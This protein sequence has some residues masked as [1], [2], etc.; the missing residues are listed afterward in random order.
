MH[1]TTTKDQLLLYTIQCFTHRSHNSIPINLPRSQICGM[2]LFGNRFVENAPITRCPR[3]VLAQGESNLGHHVTFSWAVHV[4]Y[5]C[6]SS[7]S[8]HLTAG[9]T[10]NLRQLGNGPRFAVVALPVMRKEFNSV[11]SKLHIFLESLI[12]SAG[13]RERFIFSMCA[14]HPTRS[15]VRV[16]STLDFDKGGPSLKRGTKLRRRNTSNELWT[17]DETGPD[18]LHHSVTVSFLGKTLLRRTTGRKFSYHIQLREQW[19]SEAA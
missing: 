1:M 7:S 2:G 18:H 4:R 10:R 19:S 15:N 3:H 14:W 11:I 17:S 8:W 12:A 16:F 13:K 5:R 9:T 6:H